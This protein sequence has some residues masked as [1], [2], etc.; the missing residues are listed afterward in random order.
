[1][2]KIMEDLFKE[3]M[4]E[5]KKDMAKKFLAMGYPID[6]VA[7]GLEL[8]LETVAALAQDI[9]VNTVKS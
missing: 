8:H 1:M 3:L 4:E 6:K 7:E 2:C 5:E 9:P